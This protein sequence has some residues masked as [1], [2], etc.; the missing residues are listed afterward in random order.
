MSLHSLC[1]TL[2]ASLTLLT[3]GVAQATVVWGYSYSGAGVTGSGYLATA[4]QPVGGA[5]AITGISGRIG[6]TPVERL[7]AAGTYGASGGGVLF[8]D[9]L[10]HPGQ[11]ALGLGGFTVQ[12][13][14]DLYNIYYNTDGQYYQLAGADCTSTCGTAGHL[15]TAVS[16]AATVLPSIDWAF[17]Y[18]GAGVIASGVLTTLASPIGGH[19]Q[20]VGLDG[21]RNGV[22][23][24]ALFPAGTYGV[25]GGGVFFSDNLLSDV[26]PFLETGGFTFHAGSDRFNVYAIGDQYFDF[27]GA[28]CLGSNCGQPG[29]MGT[30]IRF[31]LSQVPEPATLLLACTS[32]LGLAAR[33]QRRHAGSRG[34][35][36]ASA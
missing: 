31:T 15:G 34:A 7:L 26:D 12:A 5:Y 24:N 9:N 35:V 30:P 8:S 10:L 13:G 3:A 1:R 36:P 33:R 2:A 22:A 16:F 11:P 17:S 27:A 25:S 20:I 23:M 19:Y 4:D 29:H 14:A 28:D 21:K 32:L 18:E 6:T